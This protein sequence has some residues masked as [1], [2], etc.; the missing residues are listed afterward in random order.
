MKQLLPRLLLSLLLLFVLNLVACGGPE[1][2]GP[3]TPV[4][5]TTDGGGT[6]GGATD[7]GGT[8]GGGTDG[9]GTDGG[10]TTGQQ[11][12]VVQRESLSSSG[13]QSNGR[14]QAPFLSSNGQ[15]VAFQ[16][17]A[18]NLVSDDTNGLQDVF[19]RDRQSGVTSRVSVATGGIQ[20]VGG[21]STEVT[22]SG[23][24]G[25]AVFLSFA[26]NL[27]PNDTNGAA[28]V[29]VHD[30]VAGVTT[31]VSVD[32]AGVQANSNSESPGMSADGRFVVFSSEATNLVPNDTNGIPD[33]FL[34][35]RQTG[36]TS[37]ISVDSLGNQADDASFDPFI[38]ADGGIVVFG[39]DATNLVPGDT[40][41]VADVFVRNLVAGTTTRV[42]VSSAGAQSNGDSGF[43]FRAQVCSAD[44]RFVIFDCDATNLVDPPTNGFSQVYLHDRQTGVTRILSTDAAGIPA[45]AAAFGGF[46]S[47]DARFAVFGTEATNLVP[48][49][50]IRQLYLRDLQAGTIQFIS[51][52]AAGQVGNDRSDRGVFSLDGRFI[53]FQ[54]NATNLVPDDTNGVIDIFV[55]QN[56]VVP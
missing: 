41:G 50:P 46:I 7:G 21:A 2:T 24:G 9:G 12:F 43:D 40:N 39:S 55:I 18:S 30:R 3:M 26:T 47:G 33:I 22:T 20:S 49:A 4:P 1:A 17:D 19:V 45:N 56:P 44:G 28:D 11:P 10:G 6:D 53:G 54:S 14:S 36:I 48:N 35:D 13:A 51:V 34:H 27:A 31:R 42:S 37:R 38:S 23:D 32:S 25:T 16:S 29:F 8:D 52:N 15:F 5:P